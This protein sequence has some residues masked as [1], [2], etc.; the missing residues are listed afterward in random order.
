MA[1]SSCRTTLNSVVAA[2]REA[3]HRREG[4]KLAAALPPPS[5]EALP[6]DHAA[7]SWATAI[8]RAPFGTPAHELL[9]LAAA[10]PSSVLGGL[11]CIGE[12]L[13]ET[14]AAPAALLIGDAASRAGN[15]GHAGV[16]KTLAAEAPAVGVS[17]EAG[18]YLA[19]VD[20]SPAPGSGSRALACALRAEAAASAALAAAAAAV[21]LRH[22]A[23][24]VDA[25]E[26]SDVNSS[27]DTAR[28]LAR[29][30]LVLAFPSSSPS[31]RPVL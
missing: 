8:P 10:S 4:E 15:R 28:A 23:D 13:S 30:A 3:H 1:Y 17:S 5:S 14:D 9:A 25:S 18:A 6:L 31:Q 19:G 7:D 12:H 26:C 16:N 11:V 22:A 21:A 20:K 24:A 29:S 27:I 2:T